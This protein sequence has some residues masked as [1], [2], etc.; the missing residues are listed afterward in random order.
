MEMFQGLPR[1]LCAALRRFDGERCIE[2]RQVELSANNSPVELNFAGARWSIELQTGGIEGHN[3]AVAGMLAGKI[4]TGNA[5]QVNLSLELVDNAWSKDVFVLLPAAAYNGNR[6]HSRRTAYPPLPSMP[7]D[8]QE[9]PAIV[10]G[11][12][13]RLNIHD[14]QPS[15]IHITTGDETTPSIAYYN[16][17]EEKGCILLTKQ[18]NIYGNFGV[19]V[20]ESKDRRSAVA[21][22]ESPAV[23]PSIYREG[24]TDSPSPDTGAALQTGGFIEIPFQ[25]FVFEAHSIQDLYTCFA[26][27]RDSL[28]GPVTLKHSL[29]FSAAWRIYEEKYNRDNWNDAYGYYAVG[30]RNHWEGGNHNKYQDW[31]PGWTGG[32][33]SSL[34]LIAIGNHLSGERALK[35]IEFMFSKGQSS[36]GL[37]YGGSHAGKLFHDAFNEKTERNWV[38][39]RKNADVLYFLLKHVIQLGKDPD[40]KLPDHWETGMRKL[41]DRFVELYTRYRQY[42][43]FLDV[44][45]GEIIVGGSTSGAL[46][47]GALALAGQFFNEPRYL[48][49]AVKSGEDYYRTHVRMG[50]TT[51]GPGEIMQAPDS[52]SAFSMLESLVILFEVTE[53]CDWLTMAEE[54]AE[55]CMTWC[56]S[57]D[58]VFPQDSCFGKLD[59]RSAGSV[60]ANIQNKHSAPGICTFSGD[61]LFKLWRATG[62]RRFLDLITLIAH[63]MPQYMCREDYQVGDRTTAKPGWICE[64]VNFSDWEGYENIGGNIFGS[65]W[66]EVSLALTVMELPG[67]YV[68]TDTGFVHAIDHINVEVVSRED[69][70]L[71]L[72]LTNPTCYDAEVR[73][74]SETFDL[75]RRTMLGQMSVADLPTVK[76][77]A[78]GT[79]EITC[80]IDGSISRK[81]ETS[82]K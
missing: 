79:V 20:S 31:Q 70:G 8:K 29:P 13:P 74:L 59:I 63:N 36:S 73:I 5:E 35:T 27:V 17:H 75:A 40:W 72:A 33:I 46:V 65:C 47:P 48:D 3:N 80:G 69:D 28:T 25:I 34:P 22:I 49:V 1:K 50:V 15:A 23:R 4:M 12:L 66:P 19:R 24:R 60:W 56:A 68:Q 37:F 30:T 61:S 7:E 58:Y 55:Q 82:S 64:R 51:G 67:L 45:T 38:M 21:A 77:P 53:S 39:V 71:N 9:H 81:T 43:Q 14:N 52:E 42:G 16:R 54:M 57:Y 76:I 26:E 62:E 41:A 11:D 2:T 32:G 78:A 10:I 44:E 18:G 6:Y